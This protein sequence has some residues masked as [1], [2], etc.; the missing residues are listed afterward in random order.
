MFDFILNNII[1]FHKTELLLYIVLW[2][3]SHY[4]LS[5][6]VSQY[7]DLYRSIIEGTRKM[8]TH[9]TCSAYTTKARL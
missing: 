1:Y 7:I 4:S 8:E 5:C 6:F 2:V 3:V 9:K